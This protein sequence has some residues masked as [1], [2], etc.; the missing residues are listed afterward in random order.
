MMKGL[1]YL[2]TESPLPVNTQISVFFGGQDPSQIHKIMLPDILSMTKRCVVGS[3]DILVYRRAAVA[4]R[5]EA[6]I[7]WFVFYRWNTFCVTTLPAT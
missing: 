7:T 1:Y 4:D 5:P 3:E 2:E 6:T